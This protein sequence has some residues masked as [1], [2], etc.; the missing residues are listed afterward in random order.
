MNN[1]K[2]WVNGEVITADELNRM[3]KR[4]T[5]ASKTGGSGE[6]L[7]GTEL[8]QAE[9]DALP[10]EEKNNGLYFITDGNYLI[11][12]GIKYYGNYGYTTTVV[13]CNYFGTEL[14]VRSMGGVNKFQKYAKPSQSLS[15][16]TTYELCTL[17]ENLRPTTT[18]YLIYRIMVGTVTTASFVDV[19][20]QI[21]A[22]GIVKIIPFT[23]L[24]TDKDCI[25][26]VEWF[27]ERA[28]CTCINEVAE[29][30]EEALELVG[31]VS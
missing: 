12:N 4:I 14:T 27:S 11:Y 15:A 1:E 28:H 6:G 31:G 9:Y 20:F 2:K 19:Q 29:L 25:F 18:R 26:E 10:E 22:D 21:G 23:T 13:P 17:P 7:V 8:T 5:E 30:V 24:G 3:E 16:K